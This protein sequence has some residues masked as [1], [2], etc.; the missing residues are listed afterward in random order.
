MCKLTQQQINIIE[1]ALFAAD[2][3]FLEVYYYY[4]KKYNEPGAYYGEFEEEDDNGHFQYFLDMKNE[5]RAYARMAVHLLKEGDVLGAIDEIWA[6]HACEGDFC[7]WVDFRVYGTPY[8]LLVEDI[9]FESGYLYVK[10][11]GKRGRLKRLD[12]I[13]Y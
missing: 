1:A 11:I 8:N 13:D 9:L 4:K 5:C 3:E 12:N 2:A 10:V 6:A 7:G